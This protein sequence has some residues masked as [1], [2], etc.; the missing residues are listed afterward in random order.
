MKIL[1][2]RHVSPEHLNHA[3]IKSKPLLGLRGLFG[4][5]RSL[6]PVTN[7]MQFKISFVP[8]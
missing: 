3:A 6:L 5:A 4:R 1:F 8:A 7:E 2:S